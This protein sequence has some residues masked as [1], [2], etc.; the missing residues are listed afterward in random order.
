MFIRC[1]QSLPSTSL[2]VRDTD[3]LYITL[4]HVVDLLNVLHSYGKRIVDILTAQSV[5]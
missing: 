5:R 1:S 2:A 3:Q 4:E